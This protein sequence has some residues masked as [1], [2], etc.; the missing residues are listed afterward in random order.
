MREELLGLK[1]ELFADGKITPHEVER[2]KNTFEHLDREGADFLFQI[3]D[4]LNP[5]HVDPSFYDFFI[6]TISTFL[7][8]DE[9]S[10]GEIDEQ[11]AKWLRAKISRKGFV[12]KVDKRLLA[13]LK[14]KSITYPSILSFKSQGVQSFETLLFAQRFVTFLAVLGSM[15]ASVVLFIVSTSK[16]LEGVHYAISGLGRG[17]VET[18]KQV[19][20]FIE[21]VDGYLFATVLI[22]FSIGLYELF[23]NKIDPVSLKDDNRPNWLKIKSID[24]LKNSLG[25]VILMILVVS[26]FE[27][28]VG[29]EYDSVLSLLYLAIGTLLLSGALYLTHK[30]DHKSH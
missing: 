20:Y 21:A 19:I 1:R 10:P 4:A 11:E 25:K 7:L 5:A 17:E 29:Q 24:D 28:S 26:F 16:V 3:K 8:E 23:I 12:D 9:E 6:D 13:N 22:I 14:K 27:H 30:A 18:S 2:L 15:L